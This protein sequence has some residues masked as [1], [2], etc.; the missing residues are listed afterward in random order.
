MDVLVPLRGY[1]ELSTQPDSSILPDVF[2]V[3]EDILDT[4]YETG[5]CTKVPITSSGD[6]GSFSLGREDFVRGDAQM[7]LALDRVIQ[8]LHAGQIEAVV[9]VTDMLVSPD[10]PSA[11][12]LIKNPV[13]EELL[14]SGLVLQELDVV[15]MGVKL[16]FWGVQGMC[17]CSNRCW[18]NEGTKPQ[19]WVPL[20]QPVHRPLYILMIWRFPVDAMQEGLIPGVATE[21]E[22]AIN[23]LDSEVEVVV[24]AFSENKEYEATGWDI[25]TQHKKCV[26]ELLLSHNQWNT[27]REGSAP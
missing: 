8:N 2:Q 9:F 11:M 13:S 5:T 22:S 12:Y 4:K 10:P 17:G 3:L 19:R 27:D 18:L 15:M 20:P 21:L 14:L 6:C 16:T 23:S 24:E 25:E 1:F 7:N 26:Q